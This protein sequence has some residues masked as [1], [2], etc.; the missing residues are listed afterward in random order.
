MRRMA[1]ASVGLALGLGACDTAYGIRGNAEY[2]TRVDIK[3]VDGA[4]RKAFEQVHRWDYVH[5]GGPDTF[6]AGTEVVEFQYYRAADQ[7]PAATLA[8]GHVNRGTHV[9]HA[10]LGHDRAALT[11]PRP[12]QAAMKRAGEAVRIGCGLDLSNISMREVGLRDAWGL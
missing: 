6:P 10:F 2:P 5:G 1:I 12:A 9:S 8:I 4:L 7:G 3:C 11:L